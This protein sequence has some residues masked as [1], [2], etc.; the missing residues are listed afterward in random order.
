MALI[1]IFIQNFGIKINQ[2]LQEN[3]DVAF[4]KKVYTSPVVVVK[5][6]VAG[7]VPKDVTLRVT[8]RN[9]DHYKKTAKQLGL[10]DDFKV[11]NIT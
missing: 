4:L 2:N 5:D 8:Y 6:L 9:K 10:M 3:Y 1:E 7:N 11:I